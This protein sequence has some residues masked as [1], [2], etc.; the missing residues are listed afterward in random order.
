LLGT[1]HHLGRRATQ[2]VEVRDHHDV[3]GLQAREKSAQLGLLVA[4]LH[5]GPLLHDLLASSV[6]QRTALRGGIS[7][8]AWA[9]TKVADQHGAVPPGE[10]GLTR[11]PP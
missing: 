8:V 11:E 6:G 4:M 10:V 3:A 1:L 9:V 7:V 5:A 2:S